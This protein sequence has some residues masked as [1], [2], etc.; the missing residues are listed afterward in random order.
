[1]IADPAQRARLWP[2]LVAAY[3]DF[4]TYQAWTEREIPVV[5]LRPAQ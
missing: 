5:I 1:M 3:A 4:A 2:L